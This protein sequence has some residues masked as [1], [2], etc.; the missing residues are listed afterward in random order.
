MNSKIAYL[1]KSLDLHQALSTVF[2]SVAVFIL[3]V[4]FGSAVATTGIFVMLFAYS[5]CIVHS[6]KSVVDSLE[7]INEIDSNVDQESQPSST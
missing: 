6:T 2:A 4:S 7:V 1:K 5:L 3:W